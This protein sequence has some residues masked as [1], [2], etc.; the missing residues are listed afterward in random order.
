MFVSQ[1]RFSWPKDGETR[2]VVD[3]PFFVYGY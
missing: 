3:G 2:P 1:I